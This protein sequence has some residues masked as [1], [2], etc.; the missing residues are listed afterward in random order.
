MSALMLGFICLG[1]AYYLPQ[2]GVST[3]LP[4]PVIHTAAVALSLPWLLRAPSMLRWQAVPVFELGGESRAFVLVLFVA[5]A[6]SPVVIGVTVGAGVGFIV[7]GYASKTAVIVSVS[8]VAS[9]FLSVS[10]GRTAVIAIPDIGTSVRTLLW[11]GAIGQ[12]IVVGLLEA[13]IGQ[14]SSSIL[15]LGLATTILIAISARS[16][17]GILA[18]EPWRWE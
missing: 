8:T 10:I 2:S 6:I 4:Y 1:A 17:A 7:T 14:V 3:W 18:F 9:W 15:G 11:G 5:S 13:Q 12:T 16:R